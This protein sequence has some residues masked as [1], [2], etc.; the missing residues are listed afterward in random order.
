MIYFDNN[1]TTPVATEVFDAMQP[2]LTASYGNPS[3]AYELGQSAE[4][5]VH[6][7]RESVAGLL[8]A[9]SADEIAF[10]SCG[11]ESD[12][13]AI[14]S[15]LEASPGKNHIVTSRVEHDAVR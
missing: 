13:W 8:G 2:F 15:A 3:S 9:A 11:T 7:A 10:T 5:A 14:I 4:R 12:N 1:A 6:S